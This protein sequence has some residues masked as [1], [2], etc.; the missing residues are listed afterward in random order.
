MSAM[1]SSSPTAGGSS[2]GAGPFLPSGGLV[3]MALRSASPSDGDMRRGHSPGRLRKDGGARGRREQPRAA[4][5]M[6]ASP[7][8]PTFDCRVEQKAVLGL[9]GRVSVSP[10]ATCRE[11]L[12]SCSG[13]WPD[14]WIGQG[15]SWLHA[16]VSKHSSSMAQVLPAA[17]SDGPGAICSPSSR[18]RA[19][20]FL[21]GALP[22]DVSQD[23]GGRSNNINHSG[24]TVS[25]VSSP[26][27]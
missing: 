12:P 25:R 27:A 19:R 4:C 17:P 23:S 14:S 18:S 20:I 1:D 10:T 16:L 26:S 5:P 6:P 7:G 3:S 21:S 15:S 9:S 11:G 2:L 22:P 8:A 24:L 13:F